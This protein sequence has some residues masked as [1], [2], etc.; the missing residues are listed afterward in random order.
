MKASVEIKVG[1][2]FLASVVA[3]LGIS[4]LCC[5]TIESS[6]TAQAWVTHTYQVMASLERG[7]AILTDAETAQRAYLLTGDDHFLQDSTNAQARVT[8]WIDTLR[9]LTAENPAQQKRLDDLQP[10]IIQR[11]AFLNNRIELRRAK[12][13]QAAADAVAT[14][15]GAELSHLIFQRVDEMQSAEDQLLQARQ[16]AWRADT[17]TA[18]ILVVGGG[19]LA[20]V[21]GSIAFLMTR[22]DLKLRRNAEETLRQSEERIRLMIENVQDYAIIMLDP[23]GNIVSWDAGAQRIKGYTEAE[24]VGRHFSKLYPEAAVRRGFCDEELKAAVSE[25]RFEDESWHLRKD[26]SQFWA[27]VVITPIR[28]N[29]GQLLGFVNVTRD[30]TEQKA[31]EERI[32][33]LN[34]DLKLQM[35]RLELANKELEA[36][37]YSVSHDLRAPLRH[38]DGFVDLL[39]KQSA[40]KL[41][42]RGHRYL[43]IIADSARQMGALI[44]DLLVFSRMGR[45]E[46][47]R[48]KVESD[49]LI[50]E[51]LEP[52]ASETQGRNIEWKIAPL[53]QVIADPSM[54]RQVWANLIA[55]AV[56]YSRPRNPARI[57][58]DCHVN[59]SE[60]VFRIHDN[61]V[62]FDMQYAHKLFGVFQRLH[63]S[64]EFEGTGIGLANVQRIILRHGGRV[65]AEGK[66]NEGASFY[67]TLPK[68]PVEK[69]GQ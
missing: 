39:R 18:E 53:P 23:Q 11:L 5:R 7:R 68:T 48:M 19:L 2:G 52:L 37:S 31:S 47:R 3:L 50:H 67:F 55:N 22:R 63:R 15:E 27:N 29:A 61:G 66:L 32:K 42:E 41:D 6:N 16:D 20:C 54:L 57:E 13:F 25:G 10:L 38:I 9:K 64:E 36:F 44:D 4:W 62:G 1:L 40:E 69:K 8:G 28:D 34:D 56:K 51:V 43:N 24:I 60:F 59:D 17:R 49:S 65:W 30:I 33:K 12:G 21:L 46:L 58:I 35:S 14:R 45:A 26:G